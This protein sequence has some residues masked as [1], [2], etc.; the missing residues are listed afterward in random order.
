A[1]P[2]L[3]A[4]IQAEIK[5]ELGTTSLPR[6][7]YTDY[8]NY[9]VQS[10]TG[11]METN[12]TANNDIIVG[13]TGSDRLRGGAGNDVIYGGADAT[14]DA[15]TG[16]AGN[17]LLIGGR[18]S[19]NYYFSANEGTDTIV[20]SN[21]R[22]GRIYIGPKALDEAKAAGRLGWKTEDSKYTFRLINGDLKLRIIGD[23]PLLFLLSQF[24]NLTL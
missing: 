23:R 4:A 9:A 16:G 12:G 21:D 10:G 18:G 7:N 20:D 2:R 24:T 6:I 17:D 3:D 15:L 11:V 13:G 22:D 14:T 19:D 1:K 8:K 5:K